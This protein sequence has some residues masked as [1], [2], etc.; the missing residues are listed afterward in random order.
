ME[1]EAR[2]SA[3]SEGHDIGDGERGREQGH[4]EF[5]EERH[6]IFGVKTDNIP[7]MMTGIPRLPSNP[8]ACPVDLAPGR[9]CVSI[10]A[11]SGL[12]HVRR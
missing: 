5:Q 3:A 8:K 4:Q 11:R 6:P 12:V 9:V 2:R 1:I 7:E 10:R